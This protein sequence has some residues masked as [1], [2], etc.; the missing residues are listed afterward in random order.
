MVRRLRR[1]L[2]P[3]RN[4]LWV[5]TC[6]IGAPDPNHKPEFTTENTEVQSRNQDKSREVVETARRS[7]S[8]EKRVL[9]L[10]RTE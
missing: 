2:W 5:K 1:G 3:G 9:F 10:C 8:T 4:Q 7:V 6:I